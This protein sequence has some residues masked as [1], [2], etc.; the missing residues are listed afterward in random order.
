MEKYNPLRILMA[1]TVTAVLS[2]C[3]H[4]DHSI[5]DEPKKPVRTLDQQLCCDDVLGLDVYPLP[6]NEY[7]TFIIDEND[8]VL[9]LSSGKSF[10][11]AIKL[12][13]IEGEYVL[14]LDSVVN[15]P[16]IDLYPEAIFPMVTLLDDSLET[17]AIHDNEPL[18]LLRPILGPRLVRIILTIPS[19]SSAK[20][21]I[22]HTSKKRTHQALTLHH[23][24]EL[25]QKSSFDT[26]LYARP[27]QSR[28]KVHFVE[29]GMV[30][31][32]AYLKE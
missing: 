27:S 14:Q 5:L 10:A 8:P 29:T 26:L 24:I 17:I 30:N 7:V 20:Y 28:N 2:G 11:K 13:Q 4:F 12:P 9:E 31:M 19:G 25:V 6:V 3:I 1:S 22:I 15:I 16:R 21:A 32:L 23:P 18:D